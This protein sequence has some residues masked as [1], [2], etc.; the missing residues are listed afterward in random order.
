LRWGWVWIM[1]LAALITGT[2]IHPVIL[3][4]AI[5]E[6]NPAGCDYAFAR[7]SYLL[8]W[9]YQENNPALASRL[10]AKAG[11]ELSHCANESK[12]LQARIASFKKTLSP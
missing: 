4:P 12:L 10:A 7:V 1:P 9:A 2:R 6:L 3:R 11:N 8:A 5:P